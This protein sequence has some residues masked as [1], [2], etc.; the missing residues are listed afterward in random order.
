MPI[1]EYKCDECGST[2]EEFQSINSQ[3]LNKCKICN[4]SSLHKIVS[5]TSFILKGTGWYVT[6]YAHKGNSRSKK[7]SPGDNGSSKHTKKD[8]ESPKTSEK[9]KESH[10]TA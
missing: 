3:P 5:N 9:I 2:F 6:D 8:Y 4:S 10:T 1:Y 7:E